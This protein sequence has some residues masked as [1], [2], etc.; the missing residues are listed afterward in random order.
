MEQRGVTEVKVRAMLEKATEL[1]PNVVEGRFMTHVRHLLGVW[2][3]AVELDADSERLVVV[4][5]CGASE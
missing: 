1:G 2:V 4:T 5:F 3:V